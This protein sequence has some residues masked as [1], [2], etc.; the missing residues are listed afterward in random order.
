MDVLTGLPDLGLNAAGNVAHPN[1][2][3]WLLT[4][5]RIPIFL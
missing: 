1:I 3:L 5:M 2:N 4:K